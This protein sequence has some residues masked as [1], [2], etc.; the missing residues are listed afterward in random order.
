MGIVDGIA[1]LP[2]ALGRGFQPL[3][4]GVLQSYAISMVGG[5]ALV[6]ILVFIMPEVIELLNGWRGMGGAG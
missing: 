3:H 2:R 4:N 6:A 1:R 5:A